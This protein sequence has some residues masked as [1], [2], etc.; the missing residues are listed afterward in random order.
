[1]REP[2][3]H[4]ITCSLCGDESTGKARGWQAHVRDTDLDQDELAQDAAIYCPACA[5]EILK[6]DA[7]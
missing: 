3:T 6:D 1:M 4:S 7:A 2:V 5:G